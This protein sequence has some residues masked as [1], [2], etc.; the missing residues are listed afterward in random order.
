MAGPINLEAIDT[1]CQR[2][3]ILP[4]G[5]I[6]FKISAKI[7]LKI[8]LLQA[9]N[10]VL[11]L[12]M[13]KTASTYIQNMLELNTDMLNSYRIVCPKYPTQGRDVLI[14]SVKKRRFGPWLRLIEKV[15]PNST[16]LI[17][18]ERL[19]NVLSQSQSDKLIAT[20]GDWLAKKIRPYCNKLTTVSF[21]RDQPA[22]INSQY[23]Q[24][25]KRLSPHISLS[26]DEYVNDVF[27]SRHD[28]IECNLLKLFGWSMNNKAI[29]SIFLP[30]GTTFAENPFYQL[31]SKL[32]PRAELGLWKEVQPI[33]VSP[34]LL[35][36]HLASRIIKYMQSND[37]RSDKHERLRLSRLLL[38]RTDVLGWNLYKYNAITKRRYELIRKH[39]RA[40]NDEFANTA[41]GARHWDDVFPYQRQHS[42]SNDINIIE[43]FKIRKERKKFIIKHIGKACSQSSVS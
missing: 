16:L 28:F 2:I 11:H 24:N 33:N 26:F 22:F 13:H 27:A 17:S 42:A 15:E 12:G 18:E 5:Q 7:K 8:N 35:T 4:A 6:F 38:K 23:C 40:S 34:G 30:F 21:V 10:I 20:N 43:Y 31:V 19:S 36:V 39:Y 41:W 37:F 25:I 14:N 1:G 3:Y 29:E 9:M 32:A